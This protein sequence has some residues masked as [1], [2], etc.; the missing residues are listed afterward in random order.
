M[1]ARAAVAL[2]TLAGAL[3]C[4]FTVHMAVTHRAVNYF[5]GSE[6]YAPLLLENRG[7]LEA[8]SPYP[9]YF[10]QCEALAGI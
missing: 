6:G 7:A 9:D 2:A 8:G 4:G 3:G 5:V 10:Y 1:I